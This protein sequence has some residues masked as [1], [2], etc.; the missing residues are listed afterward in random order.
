MTVSVFCASSS[1]VPQVYLDA[2]YQL[3]TLLAASGIDVLT[4]GGIDGLMRKV[5]DGVL[6]HGGHVKAIIPQFMIDAGWLHGGVKDVQITETMSQRK[7]LLMSQAD[8]LLILPGGCGT[9]D[10]LGDALVSKQLGLSNPKIVILNTDGFY[11]PLLE[12]L[13]RF[14]QQ[15]FMRAENVSLWQVADDPQELVSML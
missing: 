12:Q 2:A 8:A 6:D 13:D 1:R 3:G 11:N 4:G 14:A 9:L 7:E 10:E 15:G 5:E